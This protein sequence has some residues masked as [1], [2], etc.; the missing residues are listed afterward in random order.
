MSRKALSIIIILSMISLIAAIIT[1]LF[2]VR[3]AWQVKEDQFNDRVK[4]ALKTVVNQ[5]IG[6]DTDTIDMEYPV[7]IKKSDAHFNNILDI[8][9]PGYLDSLLQ[10]ELGCMRIMEDYHYGVIDKNQNLLIFGLYDNTEDKLIQSNHWVS[11]SCLCLSDQFHLAV[12]FPEEHKRIFNELLILPVMSG[13][14]LIVLISSFFFTIYFIIKQKKLAEM[15]SDF[16]NN[17][18]H[19]FKTPISTISVSSEM[20]MK[21]DIAGSK[22]KVIKYASIIFDENTRLRNQVEK[23]LQIAMLDRKDYKLKLAPINLHEVIT[24]CLNNFRVQVTE[25]NG[26]IK[27]DL[28][29]HNINISADKTHLINIINNLIDNG[30]KYSP[31]KPE[32]VVSTTNQNGYIILSV[33]DKGIGISN[34]NLKNIFKKFHRLQ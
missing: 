4:I 28:K 27:E 15:K 33:E 12:F 31:E 16:V 10:A 17:M 13:L 20:L 29:A 18:T 34:D 7:N 2:W 21:N 9:H 6:T 8:V 3:D 26:N 1:Q 5:M 24:Q 14:F 25:R 22:G 32:I 23:V 11:L 19:E 30:N